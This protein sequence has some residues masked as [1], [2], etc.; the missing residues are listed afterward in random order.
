MYARKQR[1]QLCVL[2]GFS[3]SSKQQKQAKSG[4]AIFPQDQK[5]K[6]VETTSACTE[7]SLI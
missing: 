6:I 1:L 5:S 3:R 7:N 4:D 2:C